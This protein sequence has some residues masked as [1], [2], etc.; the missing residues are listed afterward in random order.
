MRKLNEINDE[1]GQN[2]RHRR[3]GIV[4]ATLA[5]L[6]VVLAMAFVG[7]VPMKQIGKVLGALAIVAAL[8]LCVIMAMPNDEKKE[9]DK[10][11]LTEV[12]ANQPAPDDEKEGK[13]GINKIFH[14]ASTWKSRILDFV[15]GSEDDPDKY[16]IND[17]NRQVSYAN[18]AIV[19]SDIVGKLPG[20]SWARDYLPQAYSDFIFAI[21]LEE[22]G[23]FGGIGIIFLYL[24]LLYRAGIVAQE[25]EHYF[26][27]LLAMGLAILMVAQAMFNMMVAVGLAPVTGQPLPFI[28][29]GGSSTLANCIY[30]GVILSISISAPKRNR[31]ETAVKRHV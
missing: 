2:V 14:R 7:G 10:Q 30:V 24:V 15:N 1:F 4:F 27:A 16:K 21:I 13:G 26:P 12:A 5:V 31:T 23:V 11:N 28:S 3:A 18:I 22:L 17:L 29:R 25:C 6:L 8:G 19:K 20:N 9:N